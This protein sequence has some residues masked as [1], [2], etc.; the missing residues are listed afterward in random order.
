MRRKKIRKKYS[1]KQF[2]KNKEVEKYRPKETRRI[3]K[4]VLESITIFPESI[5][6]LLVD[7]LF[8]NGIRLCKFFSI[9]DF[10]YLT[11][12]KKL[13]CGDILY[14][15]FLSNGRTVSCFRYYNEREEEENQ[16]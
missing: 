9:C 4:V 12:W 6:S 5:D 7:A 8:S 14:V 1:S 15:Q 10:E 11:Y 2:Q 3:E 13:T 16:E